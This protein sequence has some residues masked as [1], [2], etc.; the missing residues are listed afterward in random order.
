MAHTLNTTTHTD[1]P[2][3]VSRKH[4]AIIDPHRNCID[5]SETSPAGKKEKLSTFFEHK[6]HIST[7]ESIFHLETKNKK[8]DGTIF[9]FPLRSLGSNSKISKKSFKPE[10]I[11]A[12]LFESLKEESPYILLFLRNVQ[13]ISLMEWVKGASEP[14]ETF[15]VEVLEQMVDETSRVTV[16][17]ATLPHC[18]AFARQCSQG[19][20]MDDS[21]VYVE[22]KSTTVTVSRYSPTGSCST[23]DHHWLV[24][25]VVGTCDDKLNKLS[26]DL[27]ILPWVG[28]AARFPRRIALNEC[29]VRIAEPFNDKN[30]LE[31]VFEQLKNSL[32]GSQVSIPWSDEGISDT[33]GHAYCFLP[34]PE[35][36]AMPVHVHGYFAVTDNRRSIK[37]PAHDEQGR[38]AQWNKGL[39]NEMVAPA[40]ALLLACRAS[41][42]RYEGTPL[43]IANT[44]NV[45]DPYST[46]PLYP[47]VKNIPIWSELVSPTVSFSSPLPLLWTSAC[48][49]KWIQFSEAY[50][51]PGTFRESSHNDC[52]PIVFQLLIQVGI[53]VVCLPKAV[54][55]T[56]KQDEHLQSS[57]QGQ[58]ISPRLFRQE[59]KANPECCQSLSREE[60]YSALSYALSDMDKRSCDDM[61]NVPLLPMKDKQ[62]VISFEQLTPNNKRYVFSPK[63]KSFVHL[64]QGADSLITDPDVPGKTTEKLCKIASAHRL[65]LVE[66]NIEIMC[67][68]LLPAS[69][70]S[71]CTKEKE[72]GW[73]WTPGVDSMPAQTWLDALWKW[74]A[75]N[76]V[77]LSLLENLPIVPLLASG[78]SQDGEGVTLVKPVIW[79]GRLCRLSA[80][81]TSREKST[82]FGILEQ[83]GFLIA[84]ETKMNNCDK[85]KAHPDFKD[86]IPRLTTRLELIAK[87]L[88]GLSLNSRLQTVQKLLDKEKDFLRKHFSTMSESVVSTYKGCLRSVPIYRAERGTTEGSSQFIPITSKQ[89]SEAFLPIGSTTSDLPVYPDNML[90]P[91][92]STEEK[93]LFKLLSVKQLKLSDLCKCHLIPLAIEHIRRTP[94][95]WSV[96]DNL[97]VWILKQRFLAE[98]VFESLSSGNIICTRNNTH[99]RVDKVIDPQDEALAKLF[100]TESDGDYFPHEHYMQDRHCRQALLKI[101]MKTWRTYQAKRTRMYEL[102]LDRMQSI[103]ALELSLQLSRSKFI[104][105]TLA[106]PSNDKLRREHESLFQCKFLRAEMCPTSYPRCLQGKWCGQKDQLYSIDELCLP[107]SETDKLVGTSMPTLSCDYYSYGRH[108]MSRRTF[109][110]LPFRKVVTTAI[111]NHLANLELVGEVTE[112][113]K[114]FNDTVM[115]VYEHLHAS[116]FSLKLP[117]VWWR[118]AE[119]AKF[120]PAEKFVLERPQGLLYTNLEPYFYALLKTPLYKYAHMFNVHDPLTPADLAN[121][122]KEIARYSKGKLSSSEIETCISVLNWLC[123]KK[124]K[125]TDMLMITADNSLISAVKCVYD[126]R[127]WMKDSRSKDQIKAKSFVFVHDQIPQKVAKYFNV[128][129]LSRKVAP[130]ER[131]GISYIKAGQYEDITQ[132]I[133]H[134]VKDYENNI[135]IFKELIQNADDAGATEISFLIDWNEYPK[136]SLISEQLKEWQGPALIA[137]NDAKFSDADFDNICKVAGETKRKDPLKTGRFGV[138]FCAT[139]HLTDIPSFISRRYFT[140]FDPHTSYLGDRI[141]TQQPGMRVDLVENQDDLGLYLHQFKPYEN[142][143]ECDIFHLK[144][145]GFPG[146]LFRFPFRSSRTSECSKICKTVYDRKRI[147]TL[148]ETLKEEGEE[149]M[150]FLKHV[151]KVSLYELEKGHKPSDCKEILSVERKGDLS[152]RMA[153]ISA[154]HTSTAHNM[155]CSSKVDIDVNIGS[156]KHSHTAWILSSAIK[157]CTDP[158]LVGHPD[159]VGLLP[160]AEVALQVDQSKECWSCVPIQ[161]RDHDSKLFCFLPLPIKSQLPFHVN[162]FFSIGKDRRNIT[163]TDDKSF[164]SRWNKSLAQGALFEAFNNL[165]VYISGNCDLRNAAS[166]VV[167][168]LYLSDYYSLW[169]LKASGLIGET[170]VSTFKGQVPQLT[171]PLVWSEIDGG[172]WLPPTKVVVFKDEALDKHEAIKQDAIDLLLSHGHG[173]ADLPYSPYTILKS[174]LKNDGRLF[175]YQ[176]FCEEIL[177]PEIDTTDAEVRLR[178]MKFLAERFGVYQGKDNRFEWAKEFLVNSPCIPCEGSEILRPCSELIDP[179][180]E[181]FKNLFDACEGRFP[182]EELRKSY[183]AMSGLC[184]LGMTSYKLRSRDLKNRAESVGRLDY[185]T[186]VQRSLFL[187][188]YI[189]QVYSSSLDSDISPDKDL[190]EI[191]DIPFLPVKQKPD[192]VNVPWYGKCKTFESPSQVYAPYFQHLVFSLHPVVDVGVDS[193]DVLKC[194]GV[195]MRRPGIDVIVS[196]LKCLTKYTMMNKLDDATTKFLDESMTSVCSRL[197]IYYSSTEDVKQ[198]L[199]VGEIIWQDGHFLRPDQVVKEWRHSCYP[200]LCELSSTNKQHERVMER[201][202]VK[203]RPTA[204]MLENILQTIADDFQQNP[205]NEEILAFIEYIVG[206]LALEVQYLHKLTHPLKLPDE[207]RIMREV[208][209]LA[210]NVGDA[211]NTE[212]LTK[213]DIYNDFVKGDDCYFIHSSIPRERAITLGVLSLLQAV[214]KEIEDD[215][216]L[217]ATPF[218]QQEDL[219]DR[220]NGILKKYPAGISIFQEFIQNADDAQATEIIFILDYRTN[221]PDGKLVC[222][223]YKWKRLQHTPSLCVFNNR[224]FTEADIDGITR[225]G[226]GGKKGAPDLIGKFGIGFNVAYHITDCPSFISYTE[227]GSPKYLCVFD[228]TRSFLPIAKHDLP[229]KKWNFKDQRHAGFSD[230]LKPYLS[231][232]LPKLLECAPSGIEDRNHGHVLFRLP[233]TRFSQSSSTSSVKRLDSGAEFSPSDLSRLFDKFSTSSQDMLLFLNHL[234]HISVF[235]IQ[236]DGSYVHRFTTT[237][238]VPQSYHSNFVQY[239]EAL[240]R[241]N[242]AIESGH[243]M[244]QICLPHQMNITHI[245][246]NKKE[247]FSSKKKYQWLVQRAVGGKQLS[248]ELLKAGLQQGLRPLGGVATLLQPMSNYEYRL[249][250]FLPLPI[251]SNLPVHVNGH[252]LVDDSRKHLENSVHKSLQD[253]NHSIAQNVVV[254]AYL[255]LVTTAKDL[256]FNTDVVKF[257]EQKVQQFYSLFPTLTDSA[258]Q[259]EEQQNVGELENL[260]IAG[261]FYK[262]LLAE[263]P[264]IIV[265]KPPISSSVLIWTPLKSCLF[266]VNFHCGKR[267]LTT[268]DDVCTVLVSLDLP[269]ANVPKFIYSSCS[270]VDEHFK[271]SA[272]IEPKKIIQHLRSISCTNEQKEVI[273][274]HIQPFL[275]YCIAGYSANEVKYLFDDALYLLAHDGTLRRGKL[276]KSAFSDL[277]PHCMHK[278]VDSTLEESEVG[279][280]LSSKEYGVIC[281]LTLK[282][283]SEHIKLSRMASCCTL[284]TESSSIVKRLW[285]CIADQCTTKITANLLKTHFSSIVVIPTSDSKLYPVCMSM[286]LIR[287]SSKNKCDNCGVMKKLG[288]P[289]IDFSKIDF[290]DSKSVVHP[291][292]IDALTSCF[293]EGKDIVDCFQL[294]E[295]KNFNIQLTDGEVH[296]FTNSLNQVQKK[297]LRQASKHLLQMPLF[298]TIDGKRISLTGI[299]KVFILSSTD[300]PSQGIPAVYKGQVVLN[301]TMS[302]VSAQFYS[303]VIPDSMSAKVKPEELY[304]QL[305][306]PILQTL[307]ESDVQKHIRHIYSRKREDEMGRV[308]RELR[309]VA[310]IKHHEDF[311]KVSELCDPNIKFYAIFH[312]DSVLPTSW[313]SDIHILKDLG[314]RVKVSSTEWL[315]C[316][317]SIAK[318]SPIHSIS[319]IEGKSKLLLDVLIEMTEDRS[320][321]VVAFLEIVADIEFIYS[322][323]EWLLT[324]ILSHKSP[325]VKEQQSSTSNQMVKFRGSVKFQEAALACLCKS[326]LPDSC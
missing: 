177:F 217:K 17:D 161:N 143:F 18:E 132:R 319:N 10:E 73:S 59:L 99:T 121:V 156:K 255:D 234:R 185:E 37:W 196:H 11:Q 71:W 179:R 280:T 204:T 38:E 119:T 210:E 42:I 26:R 66:V 90:H 268:N 110:V 229:G 72:V 172:C 209:H 88:D 283:V 206:K 259:P 290:I 157:G 304:I 22:L 89:G 180:V 53:P 55:K 87:Q 292:V 85:M 141:S 200:Y 222:S 251:Q 293:H 122:I 36:T 213:L 23:E 315:Q 272:R 313:H 181:V 296:T 1:L 225:L 7:F 138:G 261:N 101:G 43:P 83:L 65:Q 105:V 96:G 30:T 166:T 56:I 307:S 230:Q 98:T 21:K 246:T 298:Q 133:G 310:F 309:D 111:Q 64:L 262:L 242:E 218:G 216:F 160:L 224:K 190:Q 108:A 100:S 323:Q 69:I 260:K 276:F 149:L 103:C 274:K 47:E 219:C 150:L 212:W 9:R 140:M 324:K 50:F 226:R 236:S 51:L 151:N 165:L 240:K 291:I 142:M 33:S 275:N 63:V 194:L 20:D 14:R 288:Y 80:S 265:R 154:K 277:L 238:S 237:A 67:E 188:K 215:D 282:Y 112:D 163:A 300:F 178:N 258:S 76:S 115:C 136:E 126:D 170:L 220:L 40:Y 231:E 285:E 62:M 28:L 164:G 60:V 35:R 19:S 267:V 207:N 197:S 134:I 52:S 239:S 58:E 199:Q 139:Y 27:S 5:K 192:G 303:N 278:F 167:K 195:N 297:R 81:F 271:L 253:W 235:E 31:A 223:D 201:L 97:I 3:V 54:C 91:A 24:L 289:Q 171:Q 95:S 173:V 295:P 15:R 130:S 168:N 129:P 322:P 266:Y 70:W 125:E 114:K 93:L 284:D 269:I 94:C 270:K 68:Q 205:I 182:S 302:T 233:L 46:W 193:H 249:F 221:F 189:K 287:D 312:K 301:A 75:K 248:I 84:D 4:V 162:G 152:Q 6:G 252:F 79:K 211:D 184:V 104:L 135:D 118:D 144:G 16:S 153:L 316:A 29:E 244:N 127:N 227:D 305:V 78:D 8:F 25:K 183:F 48:G 264:T 128:T 124:H 49:G 232:D 321:N 92:S 116:G 106:E 306:L 318:R 32:D 241:C 286:G 169:N 325:E 113:I 228:P 254:P 44:E 117:K 175:K 102:L 311:C 147:G 34:L 107:N 2:V 146:T 187:C 155:T 186:A 263:N 109:E 77:S 57:L 86:F 145:E 314:L 61:I 256:M 320:Q 82:L 148:V 39:L 12:K 45:T 159:S 13:S 299:S 120:L 203:E 174:S 198:L 317:K 273:K 245:V 326:V 41:L 208:T 176:K 243:A 279:K 74:I 158:E 308:F 131:L 247:Q 250:C 137:Y 214:V 123:Q 191:S 257:D 202:G 294:H 281:P